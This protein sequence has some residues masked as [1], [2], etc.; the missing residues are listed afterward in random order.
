MDIYPAALRHDIRYWTGLPGDEEARFLADLYL[1]RDVVV[2]CGGSVELATKLLVGVRVRRRGV[3]AYCMA[4][5]VW[6]MNC[7]RAE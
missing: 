5:G 7:P 6:A 2:S 4:M 1:A 3:A